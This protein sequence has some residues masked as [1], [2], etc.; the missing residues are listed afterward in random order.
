MWL[1]EIVA[2]KLRALTLSAIDSAKD[3]VLGGWEFYFIAFAF[4]YG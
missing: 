3:E 2:S 4:G 1:K